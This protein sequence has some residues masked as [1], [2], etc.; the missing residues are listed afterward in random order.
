MYMYTIYTKHTWRRLERPETEADM[1]VY[2]HCS[3]VHIHVYMTIIAHK[4][5]HTEGQN[6]SKEKKGKYSYMQSEN[7]YTHIL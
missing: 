3:N 6:D 7:L 2:L 1:H 5:I 4:S